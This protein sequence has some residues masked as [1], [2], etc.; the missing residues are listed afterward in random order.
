MTSSL[1]TTLRPGA[2]LVGLRLR[3]TLRTVP[4]TISI[5][6]SCRPPRHASGCQRTH[7]SHDP[8][9]ATY[10]SFAL[11]RDD[12]TDR[13]FHDLLRCQAR[14]K[15]VRATPAPSPSTYPNASPDNALLR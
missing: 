8:P 13:A 3:V 7:L 4:S 2:P 15:V 6:R 10:H 11:W 9:P 1:R 5:C 14:E 12:G